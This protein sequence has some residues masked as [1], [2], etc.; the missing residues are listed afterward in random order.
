MYA[1]AMPVVL[2]TLEASNI[3]LCPYLSYCNTKCMKQDLDG[4]A[5][6]HFAVDTSLMLYEKDLDTNMGKSGINF[7]TVVKLVSISPLSIHLE[8]HDELNAIELAI[9]SDASKTLVGLL[10]HVS[11]FVH[12]MKQGQISKEEAARGLE[13]ITELMYGLL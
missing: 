8:D 13:S 6:L 12:R 9:L 7:N 2:Y 1:Y 5:P 3:H 10:Q 11:S 4:K